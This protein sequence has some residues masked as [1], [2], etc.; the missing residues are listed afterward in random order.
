MYVYDRHFFRMCCIF[1]R[2]VQNE[3]AGKL[4]TRPPANILGDQVISG[5]ILVKQAGKYSVERFVFPDF[6]RC[7]C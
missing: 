6:V 7:C 2:A 4:Q 1:S 5:V 3:A